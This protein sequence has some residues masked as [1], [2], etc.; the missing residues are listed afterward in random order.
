MNIAL[1]KGVVDY[2]KI[3]IIYFMID[4][5]HKFAV[6]NTDIKIQEGVLFVAACTTFEQQ[7][8]ISVIYP[9]NSL[10]LGRALLLFLI[11]NFQWIII[12]TFISVSSAITLRWKD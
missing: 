1:W 7:C 8:A 3:E 6:N 4:T 5:N 9:V 10:S 11:F 2:Y 12:V